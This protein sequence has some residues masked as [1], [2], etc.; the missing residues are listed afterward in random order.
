MREMCAAGVK[1]YKVTSSNLGG[2]YKKGAAPGCQTAACGLYANEV[3][4]LSSDYETWLW[5]I[6]LVTTFTTY[7]HVCLPH[8]LCK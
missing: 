7:L 1:D 5:R 2:T 4:P 6:T 8:A 3:L